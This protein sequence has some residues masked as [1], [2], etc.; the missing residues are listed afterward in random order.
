MQENQLFEY[1]VIRV[2]PKVEREEFLNV[3]VILLC[4]KQKFLRTRIELNEA[5]LLAVCS[6]VEIDNLKEYIR[7]FELICEGGPQGGSIGMLSMPERFR[8]LTS[9]RSTIVQTSK[10]HPG[11][12]S[13]A[14]EMLERL[15]TQLVG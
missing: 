12:C 13:N 4:S 1:A 3:G 14:N 10:V 9:T 5:R 8:W 11:L 6:E 2:V 15:F 7:S